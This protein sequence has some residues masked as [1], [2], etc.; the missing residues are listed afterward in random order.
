MM[1]AAVRAASEER[2]ALARGLLARAEQSRAADPGADVLPVAQ[3]LARLL[4]GAGLRRGS[5]VALPGPAGATS[6]LFALLAEASAAGSWIGIVGRPDLGVVAAA[7]AGLALERL[8]LVP[9]PGPDLV[10]VAMALLDGM[11][12]VAVAPAG[13]V[14]PFADRRARSPGRPAVVRAA[15]R[16]RLAARARQRGA[17][18]LALGE[19]PGADLELSCAGGGWRGLDAGRGRL[20]ARTAVVRRGGRGAVGRGGEVRLLLPGPDGRVAPRASVAAT[21]AQAGT[22]PAIRAAG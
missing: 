5:T 18:L 6:L 7:E 14:V 9:R 4:P 19:W 15:E 8:A 11:D 17:V 1:H 16:Q 3:P 13:P 21:D 2:L 12:V 10:P 20:R 22:V